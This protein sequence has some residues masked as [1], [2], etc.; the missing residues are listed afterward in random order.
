MDQ[1]DWV[2]YNSWGTKRWVDVFQQPQS[3][4]FLNMMTTVATTVDDISSAAA[5]AKV[6]IELDCKQGIDF[7]YSET[8]DWTV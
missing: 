8:A 5:S 1:G 2:G 7:L 6:I 3:A 4:W